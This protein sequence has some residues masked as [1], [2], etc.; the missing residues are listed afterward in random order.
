MENL[1]RKEIEALKQKARNI[2]ARL[3]SFEQRLRGLEQGLFASAVVA[4]V[5]AG[6]CTG[7]GICEDICPAGAISVEEIAK[8][9]PKR[10]TGCGSGIAQCPSGALV[11]RSVR[12]MTG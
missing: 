12:N 10:C 2:E 1:H 6:K 4:F 9:D 7:C 3:H 11:L 8:V 5:D